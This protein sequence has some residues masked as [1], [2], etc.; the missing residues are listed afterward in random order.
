MTAPP[1]TTGE[2]GFLAAPAL[3]RDLAVRRASGQLVVW[4]GETTKKIFFRSG[5]MIFATSDDPDDRLGDVLLARGM[6]S[7]EQYEES[8]S[9][10]LATGRKQGT[11][12]VQIGALT[13]K[14]LFRGLIAQVREIVLS[15]FAWSEGGWRF[16]EGQLD[17]D[18]IVSLRLHPSELIFE[19]V[20]RLAA[21]P[22]FA[23]IWRPEQLEVGIVESPPLPP[24]ELRLP[25]SAEHLL[26]A[27]RAGLPWDEGVARAGVGAR[28]A[29]AQLWALDLLGLVG[30]SRRKGGAAPPAHAEV[31]REMEA[32]DVRLREQV[33]DLAG[34]IAGLNLYQV[35]GLTPQAEPAALKQAYITL[36]KEY[37]PDRFFRPGLD[38]L[39]EAV[40]AIFLRINEAYTTLGS[41]A[42]RVAYDREVLR[43]APAERQ[44]EPDP[45]SRIAQQQFM[46]GLAHLKEGDVWSAIQSLRWAVNLSPQNPRYH[47]YLGVALTRS[48]KR[49]H[50]AEEHCK[51]AIA[52]D[53]NNSL[54]Y[55]HLG[56]VYRTGH[57]Y[58]KARQQFEQALKLDPKHPQA[59]QEL[60]Q[61]RSSSGSGGHGVVR[62]IFR[63]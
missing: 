14:D 46:K 31:R 23:E 15:P 58:E 2:L 56:Q 18:G 17:Q 48:R 41:P 16:L 33:T 44:T 49:L 47:T 34:R 32:E 60:A 20:A 25:P 40:G 62:K 63:K 9:Q 4:R 39:Q 35:L 54:Y 22:R 55:V 12:L 37:H 21:D 1:E 52:L 11:I 45:D 24:E 27:V 7:R 61:L 29:A 3:L 26:A 13:P 43:L 28:E 59:L 36:A 42:S 57:L 50:E 38:D 53:Y 19:G 6:I 51:T 8:T 10:M 30:T 5:I